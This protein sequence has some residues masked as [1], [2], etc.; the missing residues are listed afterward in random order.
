[1]V[2]PLLV[3]VVAALAL[4]GCGGDSGPD[5]RDELSAEEAKG[6]VRNYYTA[7]DN[8]EYREAW[9]YLGR[10]A[11]AALGQGF[12]GWSRSW[13]RNY[14]MDLTALT[15]TPKNETTATVAVTLDRLDYDACN[16]KVRQT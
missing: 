14:Q 10:N 2:R 11:K 6:A 9:T 15:V 13:K 12:G 4:V 7:L 1:M 8:F 16:H 3:I 5:D